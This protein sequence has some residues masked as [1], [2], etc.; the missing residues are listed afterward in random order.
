MTAVD[1]PIPVVVTRHQCPHCRRTHSKKAA[2]VAH[3]GRCWHNPD[4]RTCKGCRHFEPGYASTSQCIPGRD[5]NCGDV[6]TECRA[7]VDLP[8]FDQLPVTN[9]PKWEAS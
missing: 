5:C 6:D 7:G 8:D 9:C 1:L 4:N 2:A 3:I